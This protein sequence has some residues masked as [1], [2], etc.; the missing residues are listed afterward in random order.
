MAKGKL[1]INISPMIRKLEIATKRLTVGGIVGTYK[2][3][4]RGH[5]L[6]FAEYRPYGPEED[7]SL[8][9]WKASLKANELLVKSYVEERN[10]DVFFLIDVSDNMVFGSTSKL[11]NEYAAELV[12][13]LTYVILDAGDRV[14]FAFFSDRAIKSFSPSNDKHQFHILSKNLSDV[15][16]YGGKFDFTEAAKFLIGYL[17]PN[18]LILI[19]SDFIDLSKDWIK[20]LEV[21]SVKFELIGIIVKD[22]RDK[23]MPEEDMNIA[24]S[25]PYSNKSVLINPMLIKEEYKAYANEQEK[26]VKAEFTRLGSDFLELTTEESFV[27]PLIDFFNRRSRRW[28]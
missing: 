28:R 24:I 4:F 26:L 7:S 22:P 21:L 3:V 9:D 10:L 6:E 8:I 27:K 13:A 11:K 25:D 18:T 15:D 20:Y 14:G 17:R 16:I 1:N 12:G 19:V 5:G 23:T 2:S